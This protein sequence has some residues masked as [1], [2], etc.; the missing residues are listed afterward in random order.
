MVRL[1]IQL[2]SQLLPFTND[3]MLGG[4]NEYQEYCNDIHIFD[5]DKLTWIQPEI[6]GSVP[7]RYLHSAVVFNDKLFVYGGFA[8]NSECN[9][10]QSCMII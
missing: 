2:L 3:N 4:C 5:I 1:L 7:A 9:N 8:K 6:N 10:L